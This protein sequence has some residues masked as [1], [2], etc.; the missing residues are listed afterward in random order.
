M[1][2][3]W[4][5]FA[6][7]TLAGL[8]S[9][10]LLRA[11]RRSPIVLIY[12]A[13]KVVNLAIGEMLMIGAY[14]F[15]GFAAGYGLPVW[16]VDPAR[17]DRRRRCSAPLIER[18]VIRRML[19]E[20]AISIFMVTIGIG[21]ILVG[22]VEI[23]WT[24]NPARLPDFM[25][26]TPLFIG[27]AYV[28]RKIA[29]SLRGRE[30]P[31]RGLRARASAIGAAASRCAPP[32]PT[33][34]RPSPAASMCRRCSRCPGSLAGVAAAGAGILVG[35][36]GGI[37]PTMG[38]FGLSALVVVI[39]GG[40]DSI[41]GA[42]VGGV[43]VGLLEAYAGT[44]IGGEYKLVTTFGLLLA[45]PDAAALWPVRHR[46]DR[47]ALM[48]IGAL[49]E[50]YAADQALFDTSTQRLWLVLGALALIAFPFGAND[51]WLYMACLV[52]IHIV[53]THRAQYPHRLY[54]PGQ[55]RAGGLHGRRRL[56]RGL[57]ADQG[58]LAVPAQSAGRGLRHRRCRD[59][60]RAA[61]PAGEGALSR[62]RHHR[63]LGHPAFRVPA[64][65]RVYRR[66]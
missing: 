39:V 37:S 65:D 36:V 48:R 12:K 55:S 30:P 22:I 50:S 4:L 25:G 9:G 60:L 20:S 43:I 42:L 41:T 2:F 6:E 52:C 29:I 64:L 19:G 53:S 28:S 44:Y 16:A 5:F 66:Q 7:V 8:G 24:P 38:V 27:E 54:R 21:S 17:A 61:E 1:G 49:K 51:Y 13:T 59:H 47:E 23:I 63:G 31:D 62:D 14:L 56:Y 35:S 58:R 26:T 10:A 15:F 57:S 46:R 45:D 34:A 32:R 18:A 11:D 3:D 33:R 40:L